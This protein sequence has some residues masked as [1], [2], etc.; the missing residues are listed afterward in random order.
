MA[1]QLTEEQI[2]EFKEAFSLFDKDGDGEYRPSVSCVQRLALRHHTTL[3]ARHTIVRVFKHNPSQVLA[4]FNLLHSLSGHVAIQLRRHG[5]LVVHGV[6]DARRDTTRAMTNDLG[7]NGLN[8]WP[9][10]RAVH[11][12]SDRSNSSEVVFSNDIPSHRY[13]H[14]EGARNRHEVFG[15][16]PH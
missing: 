8:M 3:A 2:A 13:H 15:T 11:R 4:A 5:E 9:W 14:N 16:K 1:D 6:S 10:V 7:C 12:T